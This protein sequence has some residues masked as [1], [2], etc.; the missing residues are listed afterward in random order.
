MGGMGSS[1]YVGL[2]LEKIVT[3]ISMPL[4]YISTLL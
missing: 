2:K 4:F 3:F 1:A